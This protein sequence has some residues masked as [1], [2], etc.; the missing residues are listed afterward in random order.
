MR[1]SAFQSWWGGWQ[2]PRKQP[3]RAYHDQFTMH[4]AAQIQNTNTQIQTEIH[5][6]RLALHISRSIQCIMVDCSSRSSLHV[7]NI[8]HDQLTGCALCSVH[9]AIH[10]SFSMSCELWLV[11]TL[12]RPVEKESKN[13]FENISRKIQM[14]TLPNTK[15]TSDTVKSIAAICRRTCHCLCGV[16]LP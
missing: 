10:V 16:T 11:N 9:C 13:H 5:G 2:Q 4:C 1:V 14:R 3:G 15:Y 8:Y 12:S 6:S 7:S